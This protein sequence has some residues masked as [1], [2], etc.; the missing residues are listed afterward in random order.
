MRKDIENQA[1]TVK[2]PAVETFL[3][4][5]LLA[6]TQRRAGNDQF[7]VVRFDALLQLLKFTFANKVSGG[8]IASRTGEL[9]DNDGPGRGRKLNK[10]FAFSG[11]RGS[12]GGGMKQND[13]FAATRSLEPSRRPRE[14]YYS[15]E[16]PVSPSGN[17]SR[18]FRAGTIVEIACL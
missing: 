17:G 12:A 16:S 11:V 1:G 3:E 8:R 4:V 15:S 10:F 7:G 18:T 6:G 13:A 9:V 5:A 14:E 2:R